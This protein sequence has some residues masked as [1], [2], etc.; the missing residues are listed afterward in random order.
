MKTWRCIPGACLMI[1]SGPGEHLFTVAL[2]P[3]VLEGYGPAPQVILVSF[4][5]IREGAPYDNFCEVPAGAHPVITRNSFIYY[6]EPR[7]YPATEVENRVQSGL[8]RASAPCSAELMKDILS[9]F[10]RSPAPA[11]VLQ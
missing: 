2:G 7:I 8:G 9:G 1:P 6:R 3:A 10:Q 11:K 5:S 4:S